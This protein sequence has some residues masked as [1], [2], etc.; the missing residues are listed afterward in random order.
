L[1]AENDEI[2][3]QKDSVHGGGSHHKADGGVVL[4]FISSVFTC[5]IILFL[6]S[7]KRWLS[8]WPLVEGG[9]VRRGEGSE[10]EGV[11]FRKGGGVRRWALLLLIFLSFSCLSW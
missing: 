3:V 9:G 8:N 4:F 1:N 2:R 10:V 11:N 5:C 7:W 6:C